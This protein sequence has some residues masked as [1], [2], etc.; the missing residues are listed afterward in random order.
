MSHEAPAERASAPA[1]LDPMASQYRQFMK[2]PIRSRVATSSR[3][4]IHHLSDAPPILGGS[5]K[6]GFLALLL[7]AAIAPAKAATYS[8][9][10]NSG[11]APA[12]MTVYDPSKVV[13]SGGVGG[14]GYLSLTDAI[15]SQNGGAVIDD[16]NGGQPIGG[17][18]ARMKLLIGGGGGTPADGFSFNFGDDITDGAISEE[19]SGT[20]LI[21]SLDTYDNGGGEAPALD[22][23]Y[24]GVQIAHTKY[25]GATTLQ[26][27]TNFVDLVIDLHPNGTLDVAYQGSVVYS[28]LLITG[29]AP[30]AGRFALGGRTGGAVENH[31][32]DDLTIT[33]VAPSTAA[34]SIKDPPK[35]QTVNERQSVTFSVLPDGAP[36]FTFEWFKNNVSIP[37]E[38][39]SSYTLNNVSFNDN[40][41]KIKV[42]VSNATTSAT[43]VDATLTV[44]ADTTKPAIASVTG[45]E[46]FT[47]VTVV[48]SEPVTSGTAGNKAN[49][50][51]SGGLTV[52][53]ATVLNGSTVLLG[54]SQQTA[55]GSYTL[56]VNNVADTAV[57]AN[58]ITANSVKGFVA[59]A[60][61]RG[62]LKMEAYY[63]I[64]GTPI[65]NLLDDP[66]YQANTPDLVA[67]VTQFTSR[68]VFTDAT[69]ENYGGK[70][71]GWLVPPETADYEFF[72]RSDDASQLFLSTD[73]KP[74]NATMIAEET[75]CCNAFLDP[76]SPQ[77]SAPIS[78]TAGKRYAIYALWKEGG[79]G[80]YCDVAWRKVGDPAIAKF[81]PYIAGSVLETLA[82]PGT[83]V[84]PTVAFSSP[85]DGS[86]FPSG[87]NVTLSVATVA[88][89]NKTITKVE[90]FEQGRKVGESTSS[91][92][93]IVL[94][95][96]SDDAHVYTARATDSAG[97][98]TDSAPLRISLGG[99]VQTITFFAIGDN[100][101]WS[102][103]RSGTDL[104]SAWKEKGYDDSKWPKGRTLIAD[105]STPTVAP[106]LTPFSRFD[107]AGVHI[108][109]FYYRIHF[110][111][112]GGTNGVK[113]RLR[114]AVDDGAVFYLNGAEV[115]R[116]GIAAGAA[117]D[118]STFFADH[119]NA[120]EGPIDLPTSSLVVGD[121]VFAVEVHQTSSGSSDTVFGAEL[122]ATVPVVPVVTTL[123]AIGDK[124]LFR[125][126]RSGLDLGTAWSGRT[127]NDSAWK[128]GKMLI[129]DE[130]TTTVEPIRTPISRFDDAGVHI[131]TF[132]Y[133]THFTLDADPSAVTKLRL[134]H[135]VDDGAVFY[136]NGAEVLRFGVA[137]GAAFD[138]ST[139]F[140]DHENAYEGP[141]DLPITNLVK[142]DNVFA[143]EVHQTSSGSSD[144]VFGAELTVTT[145][146]NSTPPPAVPRMT[147]A[148]T[149][150]NIVISWTST[151]TL[152]SA[153]AVVG[154]WTD[155]TG[156]TSPRTISGPFTGTKYYRIKQ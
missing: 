87:T 88:G 23:K 79:G 134:R 47:N 112:T 113:L 96:L 100:N 154:P 7:M 95:G 25:G 4:H 143:A 33:T 52:S 58:V 98:F 135:V 108:T 74:E 18:T 92:F 45:S 55:G 106:I 136:I 3:D 10:F 21:I 89:T 40:G 6:A 121:N 66:K 62:G 78:L 70:L 54:T 102:Y 153:D 103:D 27:G 146:S 31:W 77:T 68:L 8:A 2:K 26:T 101:P 90:Y 123:F 104:G 144:T 142:G 51:F 114:H 140:A 13:A 75:G 39:G 29:Y 127:F 99:Q 117:F 122:I 85:S 50:S 36:P 46:S 91:P 5:L 133:R 59:F 118:F 37:N 76:G 120:Y 129:A 124:S 80:D 28:N 57:A 42:K 93:S 149:G 69:H 110:N 125:Y 151:G 84:A 32:V 49:Y 9:N 145:L 17:F 24:G 116:F 155:I 130:S 126:D 109:T 82:P 53:S 48:F 137:A 83:F 115:L 67:Y 139:F 152:Q 71:S 63:D 73:D 14:S 132:Y 141:I 147:V 20:G 60:P 61:Q 22:V 131:T 12:G 119:E 138:F 148:R 128:E 72:L 94:T 111:F 97:I 41:A 19:G 1:C 150:A 156:A 86:T 56:T 34:T 107:D 43:S 81:L 30:K 15:G 35:S 38:T 44:V 16:F 65:Q 11:A 64:A 105:E